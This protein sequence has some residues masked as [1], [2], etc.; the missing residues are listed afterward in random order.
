M[1]AFE[2]HLFVA[3]LWVSA[4]VSFVAH[5]ASGGTRVP[6][7]AGVLVALAAW[8][9]GLHRVHEW[10][11]DSVEMLPYLLATMGLVVVFSALFWVDASYLFMLFGVFSFIFGYSNDV[12]TAAIVSGAL[13]LIWVVAWIH[14]DLP[15]GAIAT[16]IFV[17]GVANAINVLSTRISVQNHE[18]GELIERLNATRDQLASAE[19]ERGVLEERSRLAREIHDTLAQGFTSVVLLSDAMRAQVESMPRERIGDSL[20]LLSSTARENLDEARR[21]IAAEMPPALDERSFAG[22]LETLAEDLR[23]RTSATVTA[24][25]SEAPLGGSEEVV[26]FRVAQEACNNVA[27]Y[28]EAGHVSI[29]LEV[30]ESE[31][32]LTVTDDGVGFVPDA[33]PRE[34]AG[35]VGGSGL[36][37][38]SERVTEL[39]GELE[40]LSEPGAGTLVRATIP[41]VGAR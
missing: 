8:L 16:P 29:S 32:V 12:R 26:L 15:T 3:L 38:M 9:H 28:A 31:A 25:S 33:K 21:L 23:R 1:V 41:I 11:V 13:T 18:R 27:K 34:V 36:A 5:L 39:D 20:S 35:M 4:G 37:F 2:R 7:A 24:T 10:R 17:W 19:R 6:L 30:A 40:V 22:A 14:H